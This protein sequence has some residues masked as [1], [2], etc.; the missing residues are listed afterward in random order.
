MEYTI[1]D[2]A[3]G[4][5]ELR[6]AFLQEG[7]VTSEDDTITITLEAKKKVLWHLDQLAAHVAGA[8]TTYHELQS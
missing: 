8:A 4:I 6:E 7:T 2:V 3:T 5:Q 1:A